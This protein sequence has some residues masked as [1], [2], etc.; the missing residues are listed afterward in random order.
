LPNRRSNAAGMALAFACILQLGQF[1][2]F[3][4]E[5]PGTHEEH[6]RHLGFL[7]GSVY[8]IHEDKWML[9]IGAEYEYVL[10]YWNRLLGIGVGAEMVFDEHKHYVISLLLPVHPIDKLTLFVS[11]GVMFIEREEPGTRFAVH[12]G[13]EYE[14]DLEKYFLAPEFEVAFAGDDIHVMLG[15][16]IGFGF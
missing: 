15:I 3:C 13:A 10:P 12:L 8:N 11:P 5:K 6:A 7:I 9:G 2:G 16:H 1:P 4:Q 14:F